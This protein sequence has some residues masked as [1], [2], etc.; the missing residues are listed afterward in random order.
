MECPVPQPLS[1]QTTCLARLKLDARTSVLAEHREHYAVRDFASRIACDVINPDIR[2]PVARVAHYQAGGTPLLWYRADFSELVVDAT[3]LSDLDVVDMTSLPVGETR[4]IGRR[5]E[6]I[7]GL[8]SDRDLVAFLLEA[9]VI[10][11]WVHLGASLCLVA[12]DCS[13]DAYTARFTG[14]HVYMTQKK[15]VQA[16]AFSVSID[17]DGLIHVKGGE[18]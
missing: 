15:N 5:N 11:T 8:V 14:T 3:A 10:A 6:R 18:R 16:L 1:G 13:G 9:R 2:H 4:T 12:E 17:G 7:L